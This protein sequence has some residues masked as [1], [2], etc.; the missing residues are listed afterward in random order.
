[1]ANGKY[2]AVDLEKP[3]VSSPL[4]HVVMCRACGKNK[5]KDNYRLGMLEYCSA[6][7]K[8]LDRVDS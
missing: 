2:D 1:M 5:A 8:I 4:E 3:T 6:K 7:C